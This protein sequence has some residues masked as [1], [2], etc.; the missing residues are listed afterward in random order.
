MKIKRFVEKK[1]EEMYK[2][3]NKEYLEK[4]GEADEF[5]DGGYQWRWPGL[6]REEAIKGILKVAKNEQEAAIAL[7][8]VFEKLKLR[9]E[10]ISGAHHWPKDIGYKVVSDSNAI[11][12]AK[13]KNTLI[14][15][16]QEKKKTLSPEQLA[17]LYLGDEGNY[18][19]EHGIVR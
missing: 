19:D 4:F 8:C 5:G 3:K 14:K 16:I 2:E 12:L 6:F 11:E 1:F 18:M 7:E 15:L 17:K 13:D 9:D 10:G